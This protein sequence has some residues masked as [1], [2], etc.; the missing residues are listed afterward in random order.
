MERKH[1]IFLTGEEIKEFIQ[2]ELTGFDLYMVE[3]YTHN[4]YY[5]LYGSNDC[6]TWSLLRQR[7]RF[8]SEMFRD[9]LKYD[10]SVF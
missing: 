8:Q 9:I 2:D 6:R 10:E 3:I 4:A 7:S 5:D 1:R